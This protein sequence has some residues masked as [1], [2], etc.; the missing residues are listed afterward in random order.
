[1]KRYLGISFVCLC[2]FLLLAGIAIA[3][4]TKG[5]P[6]DFLGY[7]PA[8]ADRV[9]DVEGNLPAP[10]K[11]LEDTT[12]IADWSFDSGG[13]CTTAG[14]TQ[15]DNRILNGGGLNAAGLDVDGHTV[16][17]V[18]SAYSGQGLIAGNA[19]K[20]G[21][22]NL[23]W[24]G[25]GYGNN[26][27]YGICI[28]YRGATTIAFDYKVDSE[29]CC[30]FVTLEADSACASFTKLNYTTFPGLLPSDYRKNSTPVLHASGTTGTGLSTHFSAS[31]T[32]FAQAGTTH[33]VYI[34]FAADGGC[35]HEDGAIA[36]TFGAGLVV[37]NIATTGGTLNFTEDFT[38]A[39]GLPDGT[40]H[41]SGTNANVT[42]V[43]MNPTLA[44]GTWARMFQH[45]T[46]NDKCT[47]DITCAW[48][49]TDPAVIAV[50]AS[51]AYG[52]GS[53]VIH[54][55]LDDIIVAPWISLASTPT[56]QGSVLSYRRFAG[57][58]FTFSKIAQNWSF[59]SHSKV[60]NTDT[61][62]PTD[63]VDCITP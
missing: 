30:D 48:L 46:D 39:S 33:C 25:D 42:F 22:K 51:V 4:P 5:Q 45:I 16:W 10:S 52:P 41:I 14:W 36:P 13:G 29:A 9:G 63:S 24:E 20:L 44:F 8:D 26:W 3:K 32:D 18:S 35:S 37:D 59:R 54:N 43:N 27:D 57:N 17:S 15:F 49:W 2:S 56:S 1:M 55:W 23:C 62:D 38:L 21:I 53:A 12:W 28:K 58:S 31:L 50:D 61:T 6:Q 40:G 34:R 11:A 47:E 19:A 7:E 60:P